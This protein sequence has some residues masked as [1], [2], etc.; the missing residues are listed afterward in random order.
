M[1][2]R[3]LLINGPNLNLLGQREKTQYGSS[4]L[5]DVEE[6]VQARAQSHG[7]AVEA[8]QSNHEGAIIDAI[9]DARDWAQ[10]IIINAGAFTH[11]SYAIFD[12]LNAFDGLVIEV[13]I[14][15]IHNRE[16]FRDHSV[17]AKRANGQCIGMGVHGYALAVEHI[18]YKL[19]G[20]E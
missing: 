20:G 8:M 14:S 11:Y 7:L 16:A 18:A 2:P 17:I 4:T 9:H 5:S 10:G 12:A 19:N 6:L 15:N 13:H 3:I 1:S